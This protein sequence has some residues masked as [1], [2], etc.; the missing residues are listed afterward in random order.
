MHVL[1]DSFQGLASFWFPLNPRA[2]DILIVPRATGKEAANRGLRT[3]EQPLRR[4]RTD[5]GEELEIKQEGA[6]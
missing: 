4:Q 3:A 1:K 6:G 2:F 5:A